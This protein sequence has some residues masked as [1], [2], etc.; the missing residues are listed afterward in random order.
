MHVQQMKSRKANLV[1]IS[2]QP[3]FHQRSIIIQLVI[4]L[5]TLRLTQCLYPF[6]GLEAFWVWISYDS[7]I[8]LGSHTMDGFSHGP[9]QESSQTNCCEVGEESIRGAAVVIVAWLVRN[10]I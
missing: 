9:N 6:G 5:T 3:Q 10:A 4:P 2:I 1:Y 8:D 7:N